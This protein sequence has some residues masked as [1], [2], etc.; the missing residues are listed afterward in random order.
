MSGDLTLPPSGDQGTIV[1]AP[2]PE[3]P[4]P[5]ARSI[6]PVRIPDPRGPR[7]AAFALTPLADVM[8]QLLIFFM[9]SSSLAPYALIPLGAPS[10][11]QSTNAPAEASQGGGSASRVIWHVSA[12]EVRSGEATLPLASLRDVV[13]ALKAEGLEEILL[14]T[15]PMATTQDVAT[16]LEVVQVANVARVRLIG[17][18]K[19]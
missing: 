1:G 10:A 8:F 14:F 2:L 17:R 3:A 12:G 9:L 6:E 16:V 13:D 15:T 5:L 4:P 11:P 18:P 7:R 19:G